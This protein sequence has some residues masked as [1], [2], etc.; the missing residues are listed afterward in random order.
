VSCRASPVVDALQ[1]DIGPALRK[2]DRPET[3]EVTAAEGEWSS[4]PLAIRLE[5]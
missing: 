2:P 1:A 4:N 5:P 3:I